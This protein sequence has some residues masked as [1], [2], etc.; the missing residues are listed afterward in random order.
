MT[1]HAP[2]D[3]RVCLNERPIM[4]THGRTVIFSGNEAMHLSPV[5]TR[6]KGFKLKVTS[7]SG[8][9]ASTASLYLSK[10][11]AFLHQLY[12]LATLV[13]VRSVRVCERGACRCADWI[14]H[15]A[16]TCK[17][18]AQS[19][20]TIVRFSASKSYDPCVRCTATRDLSSASNTR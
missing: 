2:V 9:A 11:F 20:R 1:Q 7:A 4:I 14:C 5:Q 8:T 12:T 6:R 19:C 10:Y 16:V 15:A 17:R 3:R 13:S 18:P